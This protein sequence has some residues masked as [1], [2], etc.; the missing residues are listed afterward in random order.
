[1]DI[2]ELWQKALKQTDIVRSRI[3]ELSAFDITHMPYIFLSESTVN[4]GDTVVRRGKVDVAKPM[5]VLPEYSP[6]FEG[7][8]FE[9]SFKLGEQMITNFLLVRGITFP[10]LK[11]N[12]TVSSLDVYEGK[13]KKAINDLLDMLQRREDVHRGLIVGPDD[14]WQFSVLLFICMA[15]SKSAS[16]DIRKIL[17]KF[18]KN[19][20]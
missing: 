17:D 1:M 8:E 19:I 9:D 13:L 15:V 6:Q 18:K 2:Q 3:K 10:S 5:L 7:F 20:Q 16:S 4:Q 11:Y 12:N 14:C